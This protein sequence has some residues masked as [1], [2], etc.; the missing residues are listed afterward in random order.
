MAL[1]S[2][3]KVVITGVGAVSPNGVG[4]DAFADACVRGRSGLKRLPDDEEHAGLR[5]PAVGR[6]D[7]FDP[8]SVLGA[9]GPPPRAAHR[10]AGAGRGAGGDGAGEAR[11][12]R[13]GDQP[14]RRPDPR[15]RR[16]RAGL[17]RGAIQGLFPRR[18]GQ[19]LRRHRRHPRQPGRRA[20]HR[21]GPPRA[22]P[23]RL[24][25]LRQL[26]RRPGLRRDAAPVRPR[27][28]DGCR[29]QRR[30]AG[31][32][33][34]SAASSAWASSAQSPTT[35]PAAASRPF[36]ESRSGF[37]LAEGGVAVRPGD[38]GPRRPPRRTTFGRVRGLRQHERRLPP[39]PHRPRRGGVRAGDA[40]GPRR[41]RARRRTRWTAS[42][43]TAP[44]RR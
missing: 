43:S 16:R 36:S 7:D 6:V 1:P 2:R 38:R 42:T 27:R 21:A 22:Q 20:V 23:R 30:A 9:G 19:P 13:R 39:R 14:P 33:A 5:T 44:A 26:D 28:R 11:R 17:R 32:P 25:R 15:H 24:H 37:I 4:R 10:A 18:K 40:P 3:P 35:T 31:P 34:S 12:Q 41:T 29:R 8:L